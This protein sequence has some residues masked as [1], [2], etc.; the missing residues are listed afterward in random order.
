M[1]VSSFGILGI[2]LG[3]ATPATAQTV[4]QGTWTGTLDLS[5]G[6]EIKVEF[7]VQ[8][9]GE[10]L[11]IVMKAV[12]G[13]P[14]PVTD[15]ELSDK[16]MSFTWGAFTC[17]LE[18][19]DDERYDGECGGAAEAQLSLEAPTG[20]SSSVRDVLTGEELVET[21]QP[22]VYEA[23]RQLRPRWLRPRGRGLR[24]SGAVDVVSVY[25]GNQRMGSVDFLRSLPPRA[26][27][28]LRLYT[29]AEATTIF[30]TGN[31]GG[32]IAITRR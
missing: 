30:G 1:R 11:Q 17:S 4:K 25:M 31:M 28:E 3:L 6:P 21:E 16:G 29:A 10:S 19:K 9:E 7:T 5:N 14:Q 18:R 27:G 15:V 13:P 12:N 8:G 23:L 2:A 20:R 26:V 24:M 22:T 32:A